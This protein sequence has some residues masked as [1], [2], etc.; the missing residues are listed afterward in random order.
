MCFVT[1]YPPNHARLS[2]YAQ[3][4]VKE[5]AQKPSISKIVIL[6][7]KV[8]GQSQQ[9]SENSKIEVQRVWKPDSPLSILK[10]LWYALKQRPN[11]IH[12]NLHF[13][14]YGK[15]RLANFMGFLLIPLSKIC[16]LKTMV[17][18]H[19]L[20]EKVDL[21]KVRLKPTLIN[22]TGIILATKLVLAAP[23]VI[24]TVPSYAQYLKQRYGHRGLK[25]IPHG[26]S[27]NVNLQKIS[28]NGKIILMFGHMG[29]SKGLPTMFQVYEEISKEQNNVKL[30]IA[31]DSHPNFSGYLEEIKKTAPTGIE[32]LG[33]LQEDEMEKVFNMADVVVLPYT[34]ATGTSGVFHLACGYGKPIV[35]SSLPEIKELVNEGAAAALTPPGN[36]RFLKDAIVRV[37]YDKEVASKMGEQNLKFAEQEQWSSVASAY[38]RAYLNLRKQ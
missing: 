31:G 2:E 29:P 8:N 7:D 20:G 38:E 34:T 25:Y 18:L 28:H 4:L 27:V 36:A 23:S 30:I 33:Y 6:A 16:G 22:K 24:V 14:S 21:E 5:I 1:S 19:N 35:A 17:L 37:L 26:T 12:Y 3:C 11:I 10:I 9:F 15:T 32:F 13:Q